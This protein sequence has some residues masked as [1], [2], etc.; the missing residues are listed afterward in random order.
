MT[1]RIPKTLVVSSSVYP[2]RSGSAIVMEKLI[3]A[4]SRDEMAAVGELSPFQK[5]IE[6]SDNKPQFYYFRSRLSFFGRGAR[7]F[8]KVRWRFHQRLIRKLCK[9]IEAE[10]CQQVLGVYPDDFYCY[11]A[12]KAAEKKGLP[13][14]SYFHNTF[15]ENTAI[16]RS[17]SEPIQKEIFSGSSRIGVMSDGMKEYYI[18]QYTDFPSEK[19]QAIP[20]TIEVQPVPEKEPFRIESNPK[21]RIVMFGNFN[22][23]NLDAT[24][25][26]CKSALSDR[27]FSLTIYS[28]V[29]QMMLKNRGI[30][31][32]EMEYGGTLS[33]LGY[34]ELINKLRE[35]DVIALPHGFDGAYG[36]VE[37]QTIF[38][39]RTLPMLVSNRP[40][41]VH[42]PSHS[43]LA[44]FFLDRNAGEVCTQATNE[45]VLRQLIGLVESTDRI[46][47]VTES[48]I[49]ASKMFARD[50]V[51]KELC[52]I[53]NSQ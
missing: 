14:Y 4:F 53:L 42:A 2:K 19:F 15:V 8:A 35:Y 40:V 39:T 20:H 47:Q 48:A 30:P 23:S 34:Q 10:G 33:D 22:E 9:V 27:R 12:C 31:M 18:S 11:A 38:P 43:F 52:K 45:E 13:F 50:T 6:R 17:H 28:D 37:Y 25:R 7:F 41:F 1:L 29:P 46:R 26:F 44:K 51:V 24:I 36:N 49:N 5:P 21:I 16:T 3:D 32:H